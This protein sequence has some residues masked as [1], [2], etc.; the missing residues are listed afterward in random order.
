MTPGSAACSECGIIHQSGKISCCGLGGSWFGNCASAPNTQFSHTWHEGVQACEAR[1]FQTVVGQQ[2]DAAQPKRNI[3]P[4][5]VQKSILYSAGRKTPKTFIVATTTTNILTLAPD[6]STP[7]FKR[8]RMNHINTSHI[9]ST[10]ITLVNPTITT[11][12][13]Q[14]IAPHASPQI[15][16]PVN[17]TITQSMRSNYASKFVTIIPHLLVHSSIIVGKCEYFLNVV[18]YIS[19][20]ALISFS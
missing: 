8:P 12:M 7:K 9:N 5:Q 14:I 10:I 20:I 18:I 17:P 19:M 1:H 2:L 3:F 16:S 15:T 13:N 11:L 4:V 6:I